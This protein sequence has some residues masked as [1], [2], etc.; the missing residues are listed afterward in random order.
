MHFILYELG[1]KP[2]LQEE[3]YQE[4]ISANP[5][6]DLIDEKTFTRI[7]IL[8]ATLKETLR[9]YPLAPTVTRILNQDIVLDGYLVPKGT[10]IHICLSILSKSEKYFKNANVFN[11]KRW[12]RE[13]QKLDPID[14]FASLP[15]GFGVRMCIGRRLAEQKIYI[16][17]M[18]LIRSFRIK[19]IGKQLTV[20]HRLIIVPENELNLKFFKR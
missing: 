3:I 2:E 20:R 5:N 4:I 19:Y 14:M 18:K 1:S 15:F 6:N 8:K 16:I 11:P 17:L 10:T 13:N 9:L 7:P 12:L